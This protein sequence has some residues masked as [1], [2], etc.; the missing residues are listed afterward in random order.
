MKQLFV[1]EECQSCH[2]PFE[3]PEEMVGQTIECPHC[4]HSVHLT[5]T[6][7][8]KPASFWF[9]KVMA[10]RFFICLIYG[11]EGMMIFA[12]AN[13]INAKVAIEI[14]IEVLLPLVALH[15]YIA[16]LTYL[17]LKST[18][19]DFETRPPSWLS[20][21]DVIHS[22]IRIREN[23][24][25]AR[26]KFLLVAG[27]QIF[28]M[29]FVE[30]PSNM[31]FYLVLPFVTTVGLVLQIASNGPKSTSSPIPLR[32]PKPKFHLPAINIPK[33][34]M[35]YASG[36]FLAIV[37]LVWLA[38]KFFSSITEYRQANNPVMHQKTKE[39]WQKLNAIEQT[40]ARDQSNAG[41]RAYYYSQVDLLDVDP[42]LITHVQNMVFVAK[43]YQ[44]LDD[45]IREEIRQ[46]SQSRAETAQ[47]MQVAGALVGLFASGNSRSM[48]EIQ[49]NLSA[50]VTSG[51]I[52]GQTANYFQ[53]EMMWNDIKAKYG[54]QIDEFQT[55]FNGLA[56]ERNSLSEH[57]SKKYQDTFLS[58]Y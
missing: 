52:A 54:K 47:V 26:N 40:L 35:A 31:A 10:A 3:Y 16:S 8:S 39:A 29:I 23:A 17:T 44:Q 30:L 41:T 13:L 25:S 7:K 4:S 33:R 50:G 37:M 45:Q 5:G 42:K 24:L 6:P 28:Y 51:Q 48:S 34:K 58:A 36:G 49:N 19:T 1:R 12:S 32:D 43:A 22:Y 38:P 57:F 56:A 9:P 55:T 21:L 20:F 11:I 2:G 18:Q 46:K 27:I 14:A 15:T 53:E